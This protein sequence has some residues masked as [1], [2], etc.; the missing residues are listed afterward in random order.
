MAAEPASVLDGTHRTDRS[1]QTVPGPGVAVLMRSLWLFLAIVAALHLGTARAEMAAANLQV[2]AQVLPHARLQADT[3]PVSIT[4]ADV[5]RGY[6]YVSRHYRLQTNAPDR[7]VLQLNPRVGLT[8]SIEVEGFRALVRMQDTSLEITQPLARQ[9]TLNYR[10]WLS[11]GAN[12]GRYAMPV[13]LAAI[14]R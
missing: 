2:S 6:L 3:S 14:V 4:A 7:V 10:L 5:Q 13:Q 12:P 1:V 9:F 8:D 11:A